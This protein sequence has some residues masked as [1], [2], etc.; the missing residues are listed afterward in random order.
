MSGKVFSLLRARAL[1]HNRHCIC[2]RLVQSRAHRPYSK[3]IGSEQMNAFET[4]GELKSHL[5]KALYAQLRK[6]CLEQLGSTQHHAARVRSRSQDLTCPFNS[7]KLAMLPPQP[8]EKALGRAGW[9]ISC[10]THIN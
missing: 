10:K 1:P 4:E 7:C 3:N 8:I 5:F 6:E 9:S 2:Q